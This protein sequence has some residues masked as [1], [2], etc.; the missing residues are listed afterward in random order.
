MAY[1][2]EGHSS[3]MTLV[4]TIEDGAPMII[5]EHQL[6]HAK[7]LPHPSWDYHID[8]ADYIFDLQGKLAMA[9]LR[10]W[11][12]NLEP[13]FKVFKLVDIHIHIPPNSSPSS[14]C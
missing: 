2:M 9:S 4:R 13:F 12:P 10:T 5:A 1:V 6:S 3:N 11:L 7:D 8:Y 14:C